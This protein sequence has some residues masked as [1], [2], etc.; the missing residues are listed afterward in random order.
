M[1]DDFQKCHRCGGVPCSHVVALINDRGDRIADL[2]SRLAALKAQMPGAIDYDR[3]WVTLRA[4]REE[5]MAEVERAKSLVSKQADD[6]GLWFEAQTAP[7]AYL[8]QELRRLHKAVEG[9]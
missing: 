1:S 3:M 8:Q 2:E 7:E 5:A 9:E 4:E 6:P